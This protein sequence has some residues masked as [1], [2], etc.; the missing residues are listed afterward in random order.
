MMNLLR[1][2]VQKRG[3]N[4]QEVQG[5]AALSTRAYAFKYARNG[6]ASQRRNSPVNFPGV[7]EHPLKPYSIHPMRILL[8]LE[9]ALPTSTFDC[10]KFFLG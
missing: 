1:V 10:L 5:G 6:K 3:Q 7:F 8:D 2:R 4:E 9:Q